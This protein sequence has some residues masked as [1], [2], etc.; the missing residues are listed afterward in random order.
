M[1]PDEELSQAVASAIRGSDFAYGANLL[2][3]IMDKH[4]VYY[5]RQFPGPDPRR[6]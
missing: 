5:S 3:C 2:D 6:I 4:D 1:A